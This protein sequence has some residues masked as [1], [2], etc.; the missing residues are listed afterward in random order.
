MGITIVGISGTRREMQEK[1]DH[2]IIHHRG[3][4]GQGG[5]QIAGPSRSTQAPKLTRSPLPLLAL[6]PTVVQAI[7]RW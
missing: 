6:F 4:G 2:V 3:Q 1:S 5:H 7:H